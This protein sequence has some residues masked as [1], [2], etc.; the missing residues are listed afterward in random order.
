MW[1]LE[2]RQQG[3]AAWSPD[4]LA[5]SK[6]G[7]KVGHL[8]CAHSFLPTQAERRQGLSN[9]CLWLC[10]ACTAPTSS[11]LP[12]QPQHFPLFLSFLEA[13][14]A[15]YKRSS[16]CIAQSHCTE[17]SHRS[18]RGHS[19]VRQY[20]VCFAARTVSS[21]VRRVRVTA[22]SRLAGGLLTQRLRRPTTPARSTP[23]TEGCASA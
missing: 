12:E 10:N 3:L 20:L 13:Y 11:A 18:A 6:S 16:C 8:H 5:T 17:R 1:A 7:S 15:Q 4:A 22:D 23:I 14:S 2:T 19:E 9:A 21:L